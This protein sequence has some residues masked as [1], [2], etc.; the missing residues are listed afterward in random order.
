MVTPRS[1][2]TTHSS[3]RKHNSSDSPQDDYYDLNITH[4]DY[5]DFPTNY[6]D[7][8]EVSGASVN[9]RSARSGDPAEAS[10]DAGTPAEK[11]S[12]AFPTL[13]TITAQGNSDQRIVGGDEATPGEI[14]WQVL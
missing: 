5:Y 10:S 7:P 9:A 1:S 8:V 3:E 2:N 14:P 11:I 6:S 12:W 4:Y 13:P